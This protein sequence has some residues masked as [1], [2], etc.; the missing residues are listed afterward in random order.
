MVSGILPLIVLG[1]IMGGG[2]GFSLPLLVK[3]FTGFTPQEKKE[4]AQHQQLPK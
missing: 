1:A 4:L 3:G 2:V